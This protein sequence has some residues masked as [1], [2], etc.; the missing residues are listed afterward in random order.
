MPFSLN[1][2]YVPKPIPGPKGDQ[3]E[4][5]IKGLPG[6]DGIDGARG[7]AGAP[8]VRGP[9]GVDG[10][11][12][13]RGPP[14]ADGTDGA[15]GPAGAPGVRG[16][17]GADG[18]DGAQGPPGESRE[19]TK[20]AQA[21]KGEAKEAKEVAK[22]A[23]E[24]A[25][26]A[27]EAAESN[28]SMTD[29]F[30]DLTPIS[31]LPNDAKCITE[32]WIP[33]PNDL[34]RDTLDSYAMH[35]CTTDKTM[36]KSFESQQPKMKT[37]SVHELSDATCMLKISKY[38]R[39]TWACTKDFQ[40]FHALDITLGTDQHNKKSVGWDRHLVKEQAQQNLDNGGYMKIGAGIGMEC[41]DPSSINYDATAAY[42]DETR[43]CVKNKEDFERMLSTVG[44][45]GDDVKCSIS[46]RADGYD[47]H[48]VCFFSNSLSHE[49]KQHSARRCGGIPGLKNWH[50]DKTN[51]I[52]ALPPSACKS[53]ETCH[54]IVDQDRTM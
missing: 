38:G 5:G 23:K 13:A 14:G 26:E 54:G 32:Y 29:L 20:A 10:T 49:Q 51:F 8:G 11:D 50:M 7:P 46:R 2:F 22:E 4:Q 1:P 31:S 15:R 35:I 28:R 19:A 34:R 52:C 41:S 30:D 24:A 25:K 27:K 18:T 37:M 16:P 39:K 47:P 21:A 40:N 17:P 43:G 6:A 3:G 53:I 42:P 48:L 44:L 9:P 36:V 33:K 45:K 12:G